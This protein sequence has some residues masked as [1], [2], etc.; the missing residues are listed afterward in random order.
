MTRPDARNACTQSKVNPFVL[1]PFWFCAIRRKDIHTYIQVCTYVV[2]IS[3]WPHFLCG[4][5]P[6]FEHVD[7]TWE[8]YEGGWINH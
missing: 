8:S 6:Y 4:A 7:S 2:G 3:G 5:A 1:R